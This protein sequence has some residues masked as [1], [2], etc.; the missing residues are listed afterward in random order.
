[1]EG[2]VVENGELSF[3][4]LVKVYLEKEKVRDEKIFFPNFN[5]M[6]ESSFTFCVSGQ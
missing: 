1:M 2:L 5:R 6:A 3:E 4:Y